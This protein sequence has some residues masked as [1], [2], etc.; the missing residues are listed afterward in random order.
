[1]TKRGLDFHVSGPA[2]YVNL[3]SDF[4]GLSVDQSVPALVLTTCSLRPEMM[5]KEDGKL[6]GVCRKKP[7]FQVIL[8]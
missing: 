4:P 7:D 3:V 8:G 1:M 2:L 6:H 5:E